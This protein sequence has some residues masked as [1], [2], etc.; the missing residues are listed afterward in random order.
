[1]VLSKQGEILKLIPLHIHGGF[2]KQALA[3]QSRQL[4]SLYSRH[5]CY[6]TDIHSQPY[7]TR[8]MRK[9]FNDWKGIVKVEAACVYTESE[10]ETES[11]LKSHAFWDMFSFLLHIKAFISSTELSLIESNLLCDDLIVC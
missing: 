6:I 11:T 5:A 2:A 8:T 9:L 10:I 7:T 4:T 3:R 1:M